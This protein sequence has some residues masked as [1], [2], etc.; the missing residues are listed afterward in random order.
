MEPP[1]LRRGPM[2][3]HL[4]R[5]DSLLIRIALRPSHD[6]IG[7]HLTGMSDMSERQARERHE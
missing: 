3:S 7:A 4:I 1:I 5:R 2:P 6:G